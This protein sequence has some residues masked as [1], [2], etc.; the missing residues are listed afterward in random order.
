A[1]EGGE[2][3]KVWVRLVDADGERT[4][5]VERRDFDFSGL[6]RFDDAGQQTDADAVA[7]FRMIEA[8][9]ADFAQHGA[10]VGVTMR[11]PAGRKRIHKKGRVCFRLRQHSASKIRSFTN[12]RTGRSTLPRTGQFSSCDA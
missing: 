10:A 1:V 7:Q 12:P 11:V 6:H 2:P 5:I 8:E 9:V 4:K 3:E